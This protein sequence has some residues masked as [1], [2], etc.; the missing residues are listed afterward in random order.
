MRSTIGVGIIV[1]NRIE[2]SDM[3]NNSTKTNFKN[4][5]FVFDHITGELEIIEA[6]LNHPDGDNSAET[7]RGLENFEEEGLK[8]VQADDSLKINDEELAS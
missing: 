2:E 4:Q 6:K 3:E 8:T 7:V 1:C 5:L